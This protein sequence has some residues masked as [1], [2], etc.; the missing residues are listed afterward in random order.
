MC[1]DVPPLPPSPLLFSAFSPLPHFPT[2][3]FYIR[4]FFPPS[5]HLSL[6]P[7]DFCFEPDTM[8][9]RKTPPLFDKQLFSLLSSSKP[10][11][12]STLLPQTDWTL[13]L[14]PSSKE[15]SNPFSRLSPGFLPALFHSLG[16][17]RNQYLL[18]TS[19]LQGKTDIELQIPPL[20]LML[21]LPFPSPSPQQLYAP[22][23]LSYPGF[24]FNGSDWDYDWD[25][26]RVNR[27]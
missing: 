26:N 19:T 21:I 10:R 9:L 20:S 12:N 1:M 6:F 14:C 16:K 5:S 23:N 13:S 4:A 15:L 8:P 18:P 17:L 2:L 25:C 11:R 24:A 27:R 22:R 7:F 3:S